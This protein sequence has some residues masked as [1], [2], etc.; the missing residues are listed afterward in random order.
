MTA[1][2]SLSSTVFPKACLC[3]L[4]YDAASWA[5][6]RLVGRSADDVEVLELRDCV[7]KSTL[8]VLVS[9]TLAET[10]ALLERALHLLTRER[11]LMACAGD[12]S[13]LALVADLQAAVARLS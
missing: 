9:P 4:S 12:H 8:A 11:S 13:A 6:L 10:R 3:G 7:C 2:S 1:V 5:R